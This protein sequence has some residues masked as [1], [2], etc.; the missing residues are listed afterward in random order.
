MFV[1]FLRQKF[2]PRKAGLKNNYQR[3]GFKLSWRKLKLKNVLTGKWINEN[4]ISEVRLL[5]HAL[6]RHSGGY[7]FYPGI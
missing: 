6:V 5:R 1:Q 3:N 4:Q 2:T 7:F